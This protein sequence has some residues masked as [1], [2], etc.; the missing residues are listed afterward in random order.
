VTYPNANDTVNIAQ[1]VDQVVTLRG[2]PMILRDSI[3]APK[4]PSVVNLS[5]TDLRHRLNALRHKPTSERS[6]FL[7]IAASSIPGYNRLEKLSYIKERF[8][9][10]PGYLDLNWKYHDQSAAI[11]VE[12]CDHTHSVQAHQMIAEKFTKL[13]IS[14]IDDLRQLLHRSSLTTP[15]IQRNLNPHQDPT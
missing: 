8:Q 4:R 11:I 7:L 10:M 1:I 5:L 13:K 3:H 14:I 6:G 12:F 9:E 15:H 2:T